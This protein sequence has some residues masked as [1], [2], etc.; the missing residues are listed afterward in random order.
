ME[1]SSIAFVTSTVKY[2]IDSDTYQQVFN[3]N[4]EKLFRSM[5]VTDMLIDSIFE[6][7]SLAG[8]LDGIKSQLTKDEKARKILKVP[9][10]ESSET[11]KSFISALEVNEHKHVADVFRTKSSDHL[12]SD[13]RYE[14]LR[15]KRTDLCKY[16][17]PECGILDELISLKVFS[18]SDTEKVKSL[19]TWNEKVGKIVDILSRTTNSNFDNFIKGLSKV[20]QEHV[21]YVLTGAGSPPMSEAI[22]KRLRY[23]RPE[24]IET[25]DAGVY[26]PL[27]CEM[28]KREVFK[29]FDQQRV[30]AL[31][32][33]QWK[34]I[35]LLLDILERKPQ[36][37]FF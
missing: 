9:I 27:L 18:S 22:L 32:R 12:M 8:K 20:S 25:M 14:L 23:K 37:V 29:P 17:D 5:N 19:N 26:C 21:A 4:R 35:E 31:D 1:S 13:D 15:E 33:I 11:I 2:D 28:V 34:R 24:I 30:E 10:G 16:L 6:I 7:P 3:A 36:R